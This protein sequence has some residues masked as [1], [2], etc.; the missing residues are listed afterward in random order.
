[1]KLTFSNIDI[2]GRLNNFKSLFKAAQE[3]HVNLDN[4]RTTRNAWYRK[5]P[6]HI[7]ESKKK[8]A[9]ELSLVLPYMLPPVRFS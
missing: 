3:M 8:H 9:R 1:M 7:D 5:N 2:E 4:L 6:L